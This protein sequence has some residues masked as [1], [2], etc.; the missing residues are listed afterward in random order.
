VAAGG[1]S[2]G[3]GAGWRAGMVVAR[4]EK[5]NINKD[6]QPKIQNKNIRKDLTIY[7]RSKINTS[8]IRC[9]Q[10]APLYLET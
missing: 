2:G 1:S 10:H 6:K 5:K 3:G 8:K 7:C 9:S 4:G